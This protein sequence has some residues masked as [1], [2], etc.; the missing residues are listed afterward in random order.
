VNGEGR[1]RLPIEFIGDNWIDFN[2]E[3]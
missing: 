3:Q 1:I 2:G